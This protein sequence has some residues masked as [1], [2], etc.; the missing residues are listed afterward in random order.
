VRHA[1]H[2]T[3]IGAHG[4]PYCFTDKSG[5]INNA[6]VVIVCGVAAVHGRVVQAAMP[7]ER[8]LAARDGGMGGMG[9]QATVPCSQTEQTLIKANSAIPAQAG[10]QWNQSVVISV[11]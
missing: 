5:R 10:I 11:K 4:A 7:Q 6:F 1:H 9:G 8:P 2:S 3:L